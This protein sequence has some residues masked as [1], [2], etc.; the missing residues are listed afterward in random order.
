M[1]NDPELQKLQA[2]H[3]RLLL[4]DGRSPIGIAARAGGLLK[5]EHSTGIALSND[6]KTELF[7]MLMASLAKY[8]EFM[9]QCRD[10]TQAYYDTHYNL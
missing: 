8:S 6:E 5:D 1:D 10:E 9:D 3:L 7:G 2:Q 4:N